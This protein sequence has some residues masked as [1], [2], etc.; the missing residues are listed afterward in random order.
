VSRILIPGK[1]FFP[2][3][4]LALRCVGL[5][6]Q[7]RPNADF[8]FPEKKIVKT[9]EAILRL[10]KDGVPPRS[11]RLKFRLSQQ[12]FEMGRPILVVNC[13]GPER[14]ASS[15]RE[16]ACSFDVNRGSFLDAV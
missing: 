12:A 9:V 14:V 11:G 2:S 10:G 3:P 6:Q 7:Y 15:L 8:A 5:F 4:T 16:I 13:E 1:A